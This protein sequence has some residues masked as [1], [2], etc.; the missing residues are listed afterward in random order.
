[1]INFKA[2]NVVPYSFLS[3]FPDG[4]G[5]Q[6]SNFGDFPADLFLKLTPLEL[7]NG[8]KTSDIFSGN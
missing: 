2:A 5:V 4:I 6:Q 8:T 3:A 7:E 1:M